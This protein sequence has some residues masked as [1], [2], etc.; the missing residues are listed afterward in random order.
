M[1]FEQNTHDIALAFATAKLNAWLK[2]NNSTSDE[3]RETQYTDFI[4]NYAYVLSVIMRDA[5]RIK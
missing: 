3:A 2:E 1:S 4:N 5:D